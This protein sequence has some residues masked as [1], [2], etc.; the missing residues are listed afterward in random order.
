[1]G[2]VHIDTVEH[3][4]ERL[5]IATGIEFDEFCRAFEA[6]TPVVDGAAFAQCT[7]W[8]DV[9]ATMSALAPYG[10]ARYA[11]IDTRPIMAIAGTTV[12]AIEYLLGNHVIAE[13][14][15]RH[16]ANAMLYAPL[17]VLVFADSAGDAVFGIDRPSTVFAGLGNAEIAETGHLLDRKVVGLLR[18]LGVE[19]EDDLIGA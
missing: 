11:R 2:A 4:M 8:A 10:L 7:T 12:P 16:D 15:F 13:T 6:L 18:A 3:R 17:R 5:N 1:M 9:V 19:W 14:M